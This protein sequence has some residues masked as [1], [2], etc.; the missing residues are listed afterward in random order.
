[1]KHCLCMLSAVL[2]LQVHCTLALLSVP[3]L[4]LIPAVLD[5]TLLYRQA[6][7]PSTV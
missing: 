6:S 1:M 5:W 2:I 7:S 4:R 3:I